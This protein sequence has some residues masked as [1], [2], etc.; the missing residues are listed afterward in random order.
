MHYLTKFM[1]QRIHRELVVFQC[2]YHLVVRESLKLQ[3]HIEGGVFLILEERAVGTSFVHVCGKACYGLGGQEIL[4]GRG[5]CLG[6][7][8]TKVDEFQQLLVMGY[9]C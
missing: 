1:L 6:C 3:T 9:I 5:G 2:R 4:W 8:C 7:L